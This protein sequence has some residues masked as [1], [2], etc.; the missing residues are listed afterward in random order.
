MRRMRER[1]TAPADAT[2]PV[3]PPAPDL[4]DTP[5]AGPA[6]IRGGALRIGGYA[7]GVLLSVGS[8][9]LLFRH[10]G[11]ANT[12]RYVTVLSLVTIAYGLTDAGLTTIGVREYAVR[13]AE[14][15]D[16]LMRSLLG[17]RLVLTLL[18]IA[19][20][21]VFAALAGY[22][23]TLVLGTLFAGLG[24]LVLS[25]QN[26]TT[27]PL[28]TELRL[29]TVAAID[30]VRQA[31]TV[32]AI[33]ALVAAGA[34]LLPFLAVPTLVA[35]V[36]VLAITARLVRGRMPLR[37][38]FELAGIGALLR[39]TAAYAAAAAVN[40]LYFRMT[41]ILLSLI[42]TA[43]QTGYFSASFRMIEVLTAI[44]ALAVGAAF[45]ILARAARD[46]STR[47]GYAVQR[48]FDVSLILGAWIALTLALAA[49]VFIDIVAGPKF[50]P[51]IA[52]L[53]IQSVAM[54]GLFVAFAATFGLLSIRRYRD[55]L[56]ITLIGL[57]A[58][59]GLTLALAPSLGARGA[60]I[61]SATT[62]VLLGAAAVWLLIRAPG[63]VRLS[64]AG[65]PR[66]A[67]AA[68]LAIA[69]ALTGLPPVALG[70]LGTVVF[71]GALL[72]LR[73]IP[74]EMFDELRRLRAAGPALL[75][76]R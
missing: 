50:G 8:V 11:V 35:A 6:A 52:V 31:I 67:L 74:D 16:Q 25:L 48:T 59:T 2:E 23:G 71:F 57:A 65:V 53:R 28:T 20:A 51:A 47:F 56:W 17:M 54:V 13:T 22:G 32:V 18:G 68:G 69:T 40:T 7:A 73:G 34:G 55:L 5:A 24:A 9:A 33:V 66:V 1:P 75:R 4:L 15:R 3:P 10:L 62:E 45:P 43:K 58:N 21:V 42:G 72:V 46:D 70:V 49:P 26:M 27:V 44:P 29:G 61:A 38:S 76:P 19:G 36:V 39:D 41:I 37:P 30:F 14:R 64:L 60:A 12:G 63:G